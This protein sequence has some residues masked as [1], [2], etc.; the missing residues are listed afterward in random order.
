VEVFDLK[1]T[2]IFDFDGTII[3][4]NELI[5]DGLNYFSLMYQG[6]SLHVDEIESLHGKPLLEQ[7]KY[8][9][10]INYEE[11]TNYFKKW[12]LEKHESK[13]KLFEG[14]YE[15]LEFL[16]SSN[17][18]LAIVTNNSRETVDLG[19]RQLGIEK[20]F[21]II[22]TSDDV[23]NK[24]PSPEGLYKAIEFLNSSKDE[25]VFI[26]DSENDIYAGKNAKIDTVLVGW[27]ILKNDKRVELNA[28][29]IIE[30][31]SD[32]LELIQIVEKNIA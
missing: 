7:M 22:V 18:K 5:N 30:K 15:V 20:L 17:Y 32:L 2:F 1:N 19:I 12:Y 3:N 31:P 26:G 16:V 6:R 9:D 27:S 29:Y 14:I 13:A 28:E 23:V 8:I 24:K 25:C 4:T 11:I 21:H 10:N